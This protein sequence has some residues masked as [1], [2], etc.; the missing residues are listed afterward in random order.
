M[1]PSTGFSRKHITTMRMMVVTS[2]ITLILFPS[3]FRLSARGAV[4][5]FC[6]VKA[7]GGRP[8]QVG[9]GEY[10][11]GQEEDYP[12]PRNRPRTC[13]LGIRT[14]FCRKG[15]D[16][17]P[18]RSEDGI[19][20]G[21]KKKPRCRTAL[22]KPSQTFYASRSPRPASG[23]TRRSAPRSNPGA[24]QKSK[25]ERRTLLPDRHLKRSV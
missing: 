18:A 11:P 9:C 8:R 22:S 15:Y 2:S 14:Y 13:R 25:R 21:Q 7:G 4:I 3:V 17:S 1:A 23:L 24:V 12:N 5:F 20:P 10:A 19:L 16:Q 6:F